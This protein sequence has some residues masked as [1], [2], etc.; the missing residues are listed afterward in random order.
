MDL[1]IPSWSSTNIM[2]S[3][4]DRVTSG[5]RLRL[6]HKTVFL[7]TYVL[8]WECT[9]RWMMTI[10]II[11]WMGMWALKAM[12]PLLEYFVA[13]EDKENPD[14]AKLK[15]GTASNFTL[16]TRQR[17]NFMRTCMTDQRNTVT[18]GAPGGEAWIENDIKLERPMRLFRYDMEGGALSP[19]VISR[20]ADSK[21][22]TSGPK[23]GMAVKGASR[24]RH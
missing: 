3:P 5:H 9:S 16:V 7:L 6:P 23:P 8:V 10:K 17:T 24:R 4:F 20:F 19:P 14:A 11:L 12:C 22:L 21:I 18:C 2:S 13:H 15:I 1:C